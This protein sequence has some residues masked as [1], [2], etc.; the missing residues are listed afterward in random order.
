MGIQLLAGISGPLLDVFFVRSAM[1]RQSVVAT[2]ATTQVF[3]HAIKVAY[4]A[5]MVADAPDET[6]EAAIILISIVM[7]LLGT[8]L[9][10]Q[11]LD[12]MSDTQFRLWSR[13]L[14]MGTASVYLSQGL[15]L[16]ASH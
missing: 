7:A 6:V 14:V 15:F 3:G 11:A 1:T 12:R 5:P 2:K 10:R 16:L 8:N 13:Y 4:F 9:S